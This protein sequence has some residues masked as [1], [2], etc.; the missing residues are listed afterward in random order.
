MKKKTTNTVHVERARHRITQET[1]AD[2]VG[3]VR[4][5]IHAIETGKI[6]PSVSLVLEIVRYFNTLKTIKI[7]VEDLFQLE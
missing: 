3:C 4:Q 5:T 6:E 2:N 1:L 7:T